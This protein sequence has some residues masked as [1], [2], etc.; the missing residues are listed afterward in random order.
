MFQFYGYKYKPVIV[1]LS[2][3]N[4]KSTYMQVFSSLLQ[5]LFKTNWD[6]NTKASY[7]TKQVM[8]PNDKH[9]PKF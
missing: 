3:R 1:S 9:F 6:F 5:I 4:S 8:R 7:E 2:S